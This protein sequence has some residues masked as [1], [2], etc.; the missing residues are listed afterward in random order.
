MADVTMNMTDYDEARR[1]FRLD[2]PARFNYTRDV[3]DAW[4]AR[5]PGKL[6]LLAVGAAG[7]NPRRFTF[8]DASTRANRAA[9]FLVAHGVGK[10]DRLFVMLP[11]I[12]EW[13]WLL[14]GAF[15]IGA[16][17]MPGTVQLTPKDIAYRINAADATVA[18]TD[19]D[20]AAK[21]DDIRD[22]CPSLRTLVVVGA[23]GSGTWLSF[24]DGLEQASATDP[25]TP[26]T[27]ASDPLLIYFTSGTTAQ[28]K[29]VLHTHA[30]YGIGHEV[31]ARFWQDLKPDDLH[32]TVSDT[33]W[34]KAAWGK[35]FGQWRVGAANFLWDAQGKPDFDLMLRMI[36]EHRVTTFCAPPTVYRQFV[37]MDLSRYDFSALRHAMAAGEP[38]NPETFNAWKEATGTEIHDGYGQTETVNIVA[39]Y[40]CLPKKPGSMGKPAPGFD[41]AVVDDNGNVLPAGSEG[42]IAVRVTPERPVGLF[43][44]YWRNPEGTAESFRGDWY[45]TGDRA[46]V[47]EDGYFWFVSRNDDVIISAGYR[48][49]PFE[50]ESACME[51]EAVAEVA[52][53]GVPDRDRGQVVK[54]VVVLAPGFEASDAL[55]TQ[56]QDHVKR[57]TAPYK[58]PRHVE[59]VSEL[60]KTV[61]GKIRRVELRE[62]EQQR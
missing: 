44:E 53:I 31:T 7:D 28:P 42:Q 60:P 56:I 24:A 49:G 52:V 19:A 34:A 8:G 46:H 59:F 14:L 62:R 5:E 9:N 25:G 26:A 38:L 48:I 21:V 41:V 3:V 36:T 61:S 37:L 58:Y 55:A 11:R 13:Y 10:G 54:A 32:W 57:V 16:V 1:T 22:Q 29:M 40:R 27:A 15:K 51:H 4:A 33:G 43:T 18:V 50:V 35:L 2:V 17:P 30:S 39:N 47:D 12:P 45:Y 20:G 6:A 23:Q